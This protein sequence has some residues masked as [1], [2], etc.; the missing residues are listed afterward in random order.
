MKTAPDAFLDSNIQAYINQQVDKRIVSA[1]KQLFEALTRKINA[2]DDKVRHIEA[3][4]VKNRVAIVA[5]KGTL[6][7]AYPP[8]LLATTARS[9]G[10][11]AS[12][13]FTLYGMNILK[14]NAR[15]K[16]APWQTRP[17][18]CRCRTSS[19]PSPA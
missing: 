17:C 18:P 3:K 15:L 4:T 5:S 14:K 1:S 11:E 16:V 10:L 19:E 7:M 13:F 6:D 2:V 8:L 12:I 9:M